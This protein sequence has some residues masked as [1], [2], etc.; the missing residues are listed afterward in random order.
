MLKVKIFTASCVSRLE[1]RIN[2]WLSEH[3]KVE[4]EKIHLDIDNYNGY[5]AYVEKNVNYD[6]SFDF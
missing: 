1:E 5:I 3:N 6:D 2:N 4:V